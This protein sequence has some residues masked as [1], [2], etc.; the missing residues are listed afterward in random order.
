MGALKKFF[1]NLYDKLVKIND[2]PQ[3][4]ALGFG[5][6][7]FLGVLPGTGPVAALFLAFVLRVNRASALLGALLTNTWISFLIFIPAVKL[8]S[9]IFGVTW[10]K[11]RHDWSL[12]LI[13][14]DWR[15]LFR[16]SALKIILP[17]IIGY[18]LTGFCLGLAAYLLTLAVI[19]LRAKPR[20]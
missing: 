10:L 17:V 15:D 7:I 11:L 16:L 12:F 13:N 19:R 4:V 1:Q 3:R 6:G 9:I 8:G 5:L 20:I 2:T 18:I 14:Y